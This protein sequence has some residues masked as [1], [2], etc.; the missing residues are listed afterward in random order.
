MQYGG[1][2]N[3]KSDV[4][5]FGVLLAEMFGRHPFEHCKSEYR[6]AFVV[7]IQKKI[8]VPQLPE[9]SPAIK[10]IMA[11]CMNFDASQRPSFTEIIA[12]L[13]KVSSV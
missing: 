5:S 10:K 9:C 6:M 8:I 7:G 3:E 13:N 11:D 1:E 12:K 2:Y 4:W